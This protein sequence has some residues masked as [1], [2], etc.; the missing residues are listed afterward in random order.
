MFPCCNYT[1]H[2]YPI[3]GWGVQKYEKRLE[4]LQSAVFDK[5]K[6]PP[7]SPPC[8]YAHHI[9]YYSKTYFKGLTFSSYT[10]LR[11]KFSHCTFNMYTSPIYNCSTFQLRSHQFVASIL[12]KFSQTMY[13]LYKVSR[14]L[15]HKTLYPFLGV[16]SLSNSRQYHYHFAGL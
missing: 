3:C 13:N 6:L 2:P 12:I 10:V 4:T 14:N 7:P 11:K 1:I 9:S 8:T 16:Y 15:Y 5:F